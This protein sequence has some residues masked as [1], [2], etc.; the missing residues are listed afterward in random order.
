M[1]SKN[2]QFIDDK[3]AEKVIDAVDFALGKRI[4]EILGKQSSK[5]MIR[6]NPVGNECGKVREQKGLSIKAVSAQMKIPQYRLSAIEKSDV[7]HIQ[8]TI[9]ESYIDFLG[10]REWFDSWMRENAD[11]YDRLK[12]GNNRLHD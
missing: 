6:F 9:L 1:N 7:K 12:K 8:P 3:M 5:D 10:I 2:K 11:V 4:T